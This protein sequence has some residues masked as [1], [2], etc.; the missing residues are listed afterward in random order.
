MMP[1]VREKAITFRMTDEEYELLMERINKSGLKQQTYIIN[2]LMNAHIVGAEDMVIIENLN[3]TLSDSNRQLRGIA[4]NINQMAHVANASGRLDM[5]DRLLAYVS[6]I[7]NM[8]K[9]VNE[10]WLSTR[11]LMVRLKAMPECVTV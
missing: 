11:Q 10:I 3:K 1:R 5:T 8:L 6:E 9:G 7:N 2:A 4:V